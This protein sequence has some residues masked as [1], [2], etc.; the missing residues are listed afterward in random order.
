MNRKKRKKRTQ[1][2]CNVATLVGP[3]NTGWYYQ[4][5][6]KEGFSPGFPNRD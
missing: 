6:L 1:G 5:V 3:F 4:P 2:S